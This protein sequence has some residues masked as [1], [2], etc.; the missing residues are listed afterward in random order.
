MLIEK[1]KKIIYPLIL[2]AAIFAGIYSYSFL[3][4]KAELAEIFIL[5]PGSETVNGVVKISAKTVGTSDS[6]EF[7]LKNEQNETIKE[8]LAYPEENEWVYYLNSLELVDGAYALE[9]I[10]TNN[11][12]SKKNSLSIRIENGFHE[13]LLAYTLEK[14]ENKTPALIVPEKQVFEKTSPINETISEAKPK[15]I[16]KAAN[17]ENKDNSKEIADAVLT[18][19]SNLYDTINNSISASSTEQT[20]GK[21]AGATNHK[22]DES[23]NQKINEPTHSSESLPQGEIKEAENKGEAANSTIPAISNESPKKENPSNQES[24]TENNWFRYNLKILGLEN[25]ETLKFPYTLSASCNNPLDSVEFIFDNLET[26]EIDYTFKSANNYGYYTYWTYK[27]NSGEI[28]KGDYLL[29]AK[30]TIDWHTYESPIIVVK[31]E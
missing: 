30:G 4:S 10:A 16:G 6:V 15:Q 14:Q 20:N 3:I 2:V 31:V 1:N 26:E 5:S 13:D 11:K 21:V 22:I 24:V 18:A 9:S 17:S 7:I 29:Y 12:I 19:L 27:L 25:R 28:K 8:M 23:M